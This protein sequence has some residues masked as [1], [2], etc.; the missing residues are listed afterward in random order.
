[1]SV[2]DFNAILASTSDCFFCIHVKLFFYFCVWLKELDPFQLEPSQLCS[3]ALLMLF[4]VPLCFSQKAPPDQRN[5][6]K[7]RKTAQGRKEEWEGVTLLL[8]IWNHKCKS[9][10]SNACLPLHAKRPTAAADAGLSLAVINSTHICTARK[11][12]FFP[13]PLS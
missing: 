13:V 10:P 11:P 9:P 6:E 5:A 2:A 1:M 7:Q 12:R 4:S 8:M 3:T